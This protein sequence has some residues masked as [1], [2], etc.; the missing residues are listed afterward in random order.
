MPLSVVCGKA[1]QC[2]PPCVCTGWCVWCGTTVCSAIR[3]PGLGRKHRL[4]AESFTVHS[5]G[6]YVVGLAFCR[7]CEN[8]CT[9]HT[10]DLNDPPMQ[11]KQTKNNN[12]RTS[13]HCVALEKEKL[14][15]E[16]KTLSGLC[17][18]SWREDVWKSFYLVCVY[19]LKH[20]PVL[21]PL[22]VGQDNTVNWLFT[23]RPNKASSM[24][25]K[26]RIVTFIIVWLHQ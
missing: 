10:M 15:N 12:K 9:A 26:F 8:D 25:R 21:T 11:K 19:C 1:Q 22:G 20:R 17:L 24:K 3:Y 5:I 18:A 14:I 16:R 23:P 4:C 6:H 2:L 7:V 13:G